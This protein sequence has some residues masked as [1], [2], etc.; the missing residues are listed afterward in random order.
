MSINNLSILLLSKQEIASWYSSDCSAHKNRLH[1]ERNFI[2]TFIQLPMECS[3]QILNSSSPFLFQTIMLKS[4]LNTRT[5]REKK[6]RT[7]VTIK[8]WS[9]KWWAPG[10]ISNF[11]Q[12]E[13]NF[14]WSTEA[15]LCKCGL[16][17]SP[18]QVFGLRKS[19]LCIRSIFAVRKRGGTSVDEKKR[20]EESEG[21]FKRFLFYALFVFMTKER[22][23]H[24]FSCYNYMWKAEK[25]SV[26]S[27]EVPLELKRVYVLI[28]VSV[29]V[30]NLL[31]V[32]ERVGARVMMH[33][34]ERNENLFL[35][36]K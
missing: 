2:H 18:T 4:L 5:K 31:R 21:S 9:E 14:E 22:T 26:A 35:V 3:T 28:I 7:D 6:M 32:Q 15:V 36:K 20:K 24:V 10:R 11:F 16:N 12:I 19:L 30:S 1:F 29:M 33:W 27:V 23:T 8:I 34:G 17:E 25:N 13:F